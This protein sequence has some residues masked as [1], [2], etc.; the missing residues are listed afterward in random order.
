MSNTRLV[1][2]AAH[3]AALKHRD[4]R[5]KDIQSSPYIIHPITVA[6]AISEIGG[7]DDP[8]ILAGALLHD[9]LEDTNTTGSEL[10]E[11][12]GSTVRRYVEEVTDNKTLP[13]QERK[14]IQIQHAAHLSSGAVLIKLGDKIANVTD[15]THAPPPDW[16][17]DRRMQYFDWAE[18]VINNC[19]KTNQQLE[20]HFANIVDQGRQAINQS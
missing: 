5:R 4:Q 14:Q 6:L 12:F 17:R 9:T 7:V 1:L 15:V 16:D 19:P 11:M 3:F 8:E 18:A 20:A 13:K 10:E 2:K